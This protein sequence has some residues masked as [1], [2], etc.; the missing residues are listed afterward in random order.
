MQDDLLAIAKSSNVSPGEFLSE[1]GTAFLN[2][3]GWVCDALEFSEEDRN[4]FFDNLLKSLRDCINETK[5]R[6][7]KNG[8]I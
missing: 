4:E 1:L 6:R 7:A 8:T 2:I 3:C 5:E